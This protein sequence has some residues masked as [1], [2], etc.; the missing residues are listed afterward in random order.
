MSDTYEPY[1]PPRV[2]EVRWP[3]ALFVIV[4]VALP[5]SYTLWTIS[6]FEPTQREAIL[7]GRVAVL[8]STRVLDSLRI[9]YLDAESLL[10]RTRLEE[11]CRMLPF[12]DF[13]TCRE[14]IDTRL[15]RRR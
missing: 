2:Y 15:K 11:G 12:R 5:W 8:D 7:Q 9:E 4:L 6:S 10:W 14:T 1:D 3:V 13:E